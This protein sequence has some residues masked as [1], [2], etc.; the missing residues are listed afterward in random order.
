MKRLLVVAA[1]IGL[2]VGCS[3]VSSRMP[4]WLPG[5]STGGNDP[6]S[7][8]LSKAAETKELGKNWN[9]GQRLVERGQKLLAKSEKLARESQEAKAEAEGLITQGNGLISNSE[10]GYRTAFGGDALVR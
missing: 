3:T 10:D 4:T 9:E 5:S 7:Q 6:G 1:F 8:M 2:S